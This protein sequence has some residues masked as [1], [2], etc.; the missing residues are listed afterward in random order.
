[1]NDQDHSYGAEGIGYMDGEY[2]G[3]SD[4]RIPVTDMGFQLADMCYDAIHVT[5]GRYFRLDD[6][7]DRFESFI[8]DRGYDSLG[9]DRETMIRVMDG[10]IARTGFRDAFLML[11]ATRGVPASAKKDLRTC[12]NRLIVWATGYYAVVTDEELENGCNIIVADTIRIPEQAVD[13]SI[14]NFGRLDF[15]RA[16]SEAYEKGSQY[17]VLLDGDGLVTEGRGW[18]IFA[19]TEGR[20][21]SPEKGVLEGITRRTVL[22][23]S[24]QLNVE[25]TLGKLH[26]DA[27]RGADEVFLTS[28]AG[29]IMPVRVIDDKPVGDGAPGP[30]TKRLTT[31]YW[32]LHKNPDYTTAVDY[33]AADA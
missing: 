1:M 26:V 29:G 6:H 22:E 30:V 24:E 31:L 5:D 25:A 10:C 2:M 23:L 14:K 32:D 13:P 19:L 11:V 3:F 7:M 27:L 33:G 17:A 4:L 16:I 8:A 18:N 12:R 15:V 28:T 21:I 20:L 9:H